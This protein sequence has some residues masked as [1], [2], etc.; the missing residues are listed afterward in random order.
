MNKKIDILTT[1]PNNLD[2]PLF[3]QFLMKNR[4]YFNQIIIYLNEQ[5]MELNLTKFL[6]KTLRDDVGAIVLLD[7]MEK[8]GSRD[9]RDVATNESL[10][11]SNGE[12]VWFVEQ[13][14]MI[15]KEFLPTV[16]S[17]M[18]RYEVIGFKDTNR[19]H[20][21]SL[22]VR[23]NII[24]QTSKDFSPDPPQFD[25]FAKFSI[26]C[27]EKGNWATFRSLGLKEGI[28]WYHHAG[29]SQNYILAQQMKVPN[30]APQE[31]LVYNQASREINI[32]LN[33]EYIKLTHDVE[34]LLTKIK[35]FI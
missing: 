1:W 4:H 33:K 31:F 21:A 8:R 29:L 7:D 19:L 2:Y 30:Y 22:F 17:A 18:D 27:R 28:S 3:R 16:M 26:E 35:R 34:H 13:D 25:H 10:P 12:W 5:N 24:D 6:K 32:P 11:H 15:R 20:P 23:R 9:W 14:F